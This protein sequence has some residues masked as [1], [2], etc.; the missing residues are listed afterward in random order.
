MKKYLK[1][2]NETEDK[3]SHNASVVVLSTGAQGT[4]T[5]VLLKMDKHSY[6]FNAPDGIT[7]A[8]FAGFLGEIPAMENV[9]LTSRSIEAAG[10]IMGLMMA[11]HTPSDGPIKIHGPA[12]VNSIL[13]MRHAF[14]EKGKVKRNSIDWRGISH[15]RY[16]DSQVIVDYVDLYDDKKIHHDTKD[17][18]EKHK[19][20]DSK[21]ERS[22]M[23]NSANV[24]SE[25]FEMDDVSINTTKD[26]E[27]LMIN[28]T[29]SDQK[30]LID[31]TESRANMVMAY[32]VQVKKSSPQIDTEA[33]LNLGMESGPWVG[34]LMK[35]KTVVLP[36]GSEVRP[37]DV[38]TGHSDDCGP[39]LVLEVPSKGYLQ[40]LVNS[41]PLKDLMA[42]KPELVIHM[43]PK[44]V[45]DNP[46]YEHFMKRYDCCHI[47]LNEDSG[48]RYYRTVHK[49][50]SL[51]NHVHG[52]IFPYPK[53]F[54]DVY[55]RCQSQHFVDSEFGLRYILRPKHGKCIDWSMCDAA[56]DKEEDLRYEIDENIF[57]G[58]KSLR[59]NGVFTSDFSKESFM[60]EVGLFKEICKR[61]D[62]TAQIF[63][64]EY[65]VITFLGTGSMTSG[66]RNSTGILLE[67]QKDEFMLLDCA[68]STYH[69]MLTMFGHEKTMH[70]LCNLK[71][72]FVSHMHLDHHG[73]V[74]TILYW[75]GQARKNKDKLI[76]LGSPVLKKLLNLYS[77]HIQDIQAHT[78]FIPH[79]KTALWER[80]KHKFDIVLQRL[81]LKS[82]LPVPVNHGC[83]CLGM[84]LQH[85]DG[86]KLVYSADTM[87]SDKLIKHGQNCDILIHEATM[88]DVQLQAAKNLCHSTV[89]QAIRTGKQMNAKFTLLTHFNKRMR[90]IPLFSDA[91]TED[92]GYAFDFMQVKPNQLHLLYHMKPVFNALY[93]PSIASQE[94][95]MQ[96]YASARNQTEMFSKGILEAR[97]TQDNLNYIE[98]LETCK[99][100]RNHWKN[101]NLMEKLKIVEDNSDKDSG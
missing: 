101:G 94:L 11:D 67:T 36:D 80:E 21:L 97:E 65:P 4:G 35:G 24:I 50:C 30:S 77:K 54:T 51:T 83:G 16:E 5:S 2:M 47:V 68:D 7:R 95:L 38:M 75:Q 96:K 27:H 70:I 15:Q 33:I 46:V 78:V 6:I 58:L 85:N 29:S 84:V 14:S 12:K 8:M 41:Q 20:G 73:G 86:W 82:Y 13:R 59:K 48:M 71:A 61:Q 43:T 64:G 69:Q 32:I 22:K 93:G 87:P 18:P 34:E 52:G 90:H 89:S 23:K 31:D 44:R 40:S 45:M 55:N 9:F 91:F 72:I 88:F 19:D 56:F 79:D 1:S 37:E 10:G 98:F 74:P 26:K 81:N 17:I 28:D 63:S 99:M 42:L 53:G 39:F 3:P 92:V 49:L 25:L 76:V 60:L 57:H 62:S 66:F 100:D